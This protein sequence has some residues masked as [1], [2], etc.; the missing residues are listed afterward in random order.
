MLLT[1]SFHEMST[2]DVRSMIDYALDHSGE[3]KLFYIGHSM[4]GTISFVLLSE[5]PEYN[6][7]MRFVVNLAPSALWKYEP[8]SLYRF[9]AENWELGRVSC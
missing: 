8:D 2:I 1:Y 6:E 4:G 9:I 3:K 5:K 7:K